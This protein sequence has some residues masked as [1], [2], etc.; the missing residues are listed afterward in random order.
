MDK[1]YNIL[2]LK[3]G[4]S[5][6]EIKKAYKKLAV[7]YHP[8]KHHNSSDEEKANAESKF[9]EIAEAYD[10]LMNPEKINNNNNTN[11][12]RTHI[13]P[14]DLF[15]Q[16][17]NMNI[18]NI[19]DIHNIGNIGSGMHININGLNIG[20]NPTNCVMRSSSVSIVNGQKIEKIRETINGVTTVKTIISG[21]P[22]TNTHHIRIN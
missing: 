19:G 12:R 7:L 4:C 5:E 16:F 9:K 13:N 15:N 10:I 11:F 6:D 14:N 3:P 17:F 22:N 18:G 21:K 2:N 1:Y 8:D 20:A